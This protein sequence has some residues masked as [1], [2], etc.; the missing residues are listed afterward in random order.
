MPVTFLSVGHFCYD[1]SPNGLYSW[2]I[3]LIFDT[4]C[5]KLGAPGTCC[6]QLSG[7]NFDRNNPLLDGVKTVYR[8][9]PRKRRFSITNTMK[10]DI[11]SSLS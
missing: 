5:P 9:I 10:W 2:R 1:V 4:N 8:E 7:A 3:R 11:G 6:L